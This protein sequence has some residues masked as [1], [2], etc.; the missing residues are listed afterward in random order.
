MPLNF[1]L[2][3]APKVFGL[4]GAPETPAPYFPEAL[5]VPSFPEHHQAT[6]EGVP[7]GHRAP[8]HALGHSCEPTH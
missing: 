4:L 1:V 3:R 8:E 5:L 2:R 7:Y 6:L